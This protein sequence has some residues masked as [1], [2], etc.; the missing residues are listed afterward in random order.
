MLWKKMIHTRNDYE[1]YMN[2]GKY[3]GTAIGCTIGIFLVCMV[4]RARFDVN[5]WGG[6]MGGI[7]CCWFSF[8][9]WPY[10]GKK[11]SKKN[12]DKRRSS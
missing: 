12:K 2:N 11:Y 4:S 9:L 7:F 8:E 5:E 1:V 6:F 3:I 10:L